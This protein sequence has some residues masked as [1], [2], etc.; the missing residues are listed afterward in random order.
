M[1]ILMLVVRE[2]ARLAVRRQEE[3]AG[4]S[5]AASSGSCSSS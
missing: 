3:R 2:A 4:V 1:L 5:R